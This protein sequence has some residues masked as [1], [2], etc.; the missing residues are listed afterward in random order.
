MKKFWAEFKKFINK[1]N[2]E[3]NYVFYDKT[4]SHFRKNIIIYF[5]IKKVFEK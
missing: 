5:L 1:G 4:F 3:N 2:C